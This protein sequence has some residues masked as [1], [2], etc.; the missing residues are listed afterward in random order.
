[1]IK[2]IATTDAGGMI[3][4]NEYLVTEQLAGILLSVKRCRLASEPEVIGTQEVSLLDEAT[5][6]QAPAKK[7]KTKK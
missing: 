6:A 7:T 3:I 1:M 5:P 4:G 2:I